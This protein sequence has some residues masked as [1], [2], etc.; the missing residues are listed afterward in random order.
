MW[1]GVCASAKTYMAAAEA[2]NSAMSSIN[3]SHMLSAGGQLMLLRTKTNKAADE[4][5]IEETIR[6]ARLEEVTRG[7]GSAP[8]LC[9]ATDSGEQPS[10]SGLEGVI[11]LTGRSVIFTTS[12]LLGYPL[13]RLSK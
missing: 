8:W 12:A 9:L 5:V 6:S 3:A 11:P 4:C 10:V 1:G 2:E 13:N 7:S